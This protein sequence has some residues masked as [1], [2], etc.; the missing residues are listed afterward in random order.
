V[1]T[2]KHASIYVRYGRLH[3]HNVK[4]RNVQV[5]AEITSAI[6][7]YFLHFSHTVLSREQFLS[8]CVVATS[9]LMNCFFLLFFS[10]IC[11]MTT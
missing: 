9:Q 10:F 3:M 11:R 1:R 4:H 2:A 8:Y 7:V 5:A 6:S